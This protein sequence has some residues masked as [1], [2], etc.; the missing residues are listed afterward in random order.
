MNLST[1][2][3][4]RGVILRCS[5]ARRQAQL[6]MRIAALSVTTTDSAPTANYQRP[7][8]VGFVL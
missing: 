6:S 1:L 5:A 4:E 2:S 8:S 7:A 3:F